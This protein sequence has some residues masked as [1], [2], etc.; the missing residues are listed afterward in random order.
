MR[1]GVTAFF[2]RIR[3]IAMSGL[4]LDVAGRSAPIY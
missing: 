4:D 2:A 1:Y 3:S